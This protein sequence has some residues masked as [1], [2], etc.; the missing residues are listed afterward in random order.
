MSVYGTSCA[1]TVGR[2]ESNDRPAGIERKDIVV[3]IM[4]MM[5]TEGHIGKIKLLV[6]QK[7]T[8]NSQSMI[9]VVYINNFAAYQT[10]NALVL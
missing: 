6:A 10:D 1:L 8:T 4:M 3:H 5:I 9:I 7:K 2:K